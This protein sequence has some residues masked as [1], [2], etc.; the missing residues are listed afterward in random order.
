M[1]HLVIARKYRPLAFDSVAGQEHVTKTLKHSIER[2]RISHALLLTGPRGVGKTSIA[3]IFAKCLNCAADDK[4]TITPCLT[5]SNCKDIAQATSLSVREIDGASNNSVDNVR[6]LIENFRTLPPPGSRYKV[7]IIDE[8]HMLSTAAFN[9]LLKSLEEP[10]PNTVF[11]LATTEVHKIPETVLS[12]CQQHDLRALPA[13]TIEETLSGICDKEG[14]VIDEEALAILARVAEGSL[15]DAE[16]ALERLLLFAQEKKVTAKDASE[17][18]GA[19]DSEA[20]NALSRAIFGKN[21][22]EAL[23]IFD[24]LMKRG[25]DTTTLTRDIV[26]HFRELLLAKASGRPFLNSLG[27]SEVRATELMQQSNLV[28]SLELQ[29][30]CYLV[31]QGADEALR[32][33][34]PKYALE[35]L[36]VRLAT[37]SSVLDVSQLL[38]DGSTTPRAVSASTSKAAAPTSQRAPQQASAARPQEAQNEAS[39]TVSWFDF[40]KF[41]QAK[42]KML[43]EQLKRV[44][45]KSFVPGELVLLG[46]TFSKSYLEKK[47]N[48]EKL[49]TLLQAYHAHPSWRVRVE[50]TQEAVEGAV[51]GSLQEKTHT[52]QKEKTKAK[53]QDILNSPS[54][55]AIQNLFPGSKIEVKQ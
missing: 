55:Q 21:P 54:I 44:Q 50:V 28:D 37:R 15:R 47:E 16:T 38:Q 6:E 46:T 33:A 18:F 22:H 39:G 7:Y 11:I 5:C 29:D 32:S 25:N 35:S 13:A 30:L 1:S 53:E 42:A 49:V 43:A 48:V 34:F 24:A 9:A 19:A 23:T 31:R 12:R 36:I 8:V 27:L 41:A 51:V 4:A 14:V 3:R 40:V 17:L 52:A 20:L 45:P 26:S 2:Q 10:P